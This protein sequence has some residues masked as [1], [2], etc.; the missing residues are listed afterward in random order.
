MYE[1]DRKQH[2]RNRWERKSNYHKK[3]KKNWSRR[4]KEF[5]DLEEDFETFADEEPEETDNY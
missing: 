2:R 1:D 3:S 5:E 4:R